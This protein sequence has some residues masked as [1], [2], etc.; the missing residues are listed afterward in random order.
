MGLGAGRGPPSASQR[1][2]SAQATRARCAGEGDEGDSS[3]GEGDS[4][5]SDG[6]RREAGA[7]RRLGCGRRERE[8]R[9][10]GTA[11]SDQGNGGER[12]QGLTLV[13]DGGSDEP[14]TPSREGTSVGADPPQAVMTVVYYNTSTCMRG[15]RANK[16]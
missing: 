7:A 16:P 1:R 3:R 5:E 8:E 14:H 13:K 11:G 9:D 10:K 15:F 6:G 12:D 4:D 2:S